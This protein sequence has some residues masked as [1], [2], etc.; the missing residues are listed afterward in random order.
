M[1]RA[2]FIAL[3]FFSSLTAQSQD[4]TPDTLQEIRPHSRSGTARSTTDVPAYAQTTLDYIRRHHAPPPGF[5]GGR[6]YGN[7]ERTLPARDR[8]G[9]PVRYQE[10]DVKPHSVHRNRG[11]ERIVTG[12]DGRAWY[13]ADHYHTFIP[14]R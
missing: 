11:A 9:E 6:T 13:T 12:S 4:T 14:L 8:N 5:E 7:Y 10:W 3:L 1:S 2:M